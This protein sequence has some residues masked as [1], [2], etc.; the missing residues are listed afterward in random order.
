MPGFVFFRRKTIYPAA[1]T[2]PGAAIPES[3]RSINI[4]P[5]TII[6]MK[7][8]I[9]VVF[10]A[11]VC[12]LAAAQPK[13]VEKAISVIVEQNARAF[14]G[15]LASDA[16]QGRAAGSAS[17]LAAAEYLASYLMYLGIEPLFGD[18]YLQPFDAYNKDLQ[19]RTR[20]SVEPDSVAKYM[21]E[22]HHVLHMRNVAGIIR[23]ER[24]DEFVVV[25]AHFDHMGSDGNLVGD[26][27]YNGADDNASG[28][29]AVMQIARAFAE[30]SGHRPLRSIIFAFW[31]GEE[32]GLLGS[33]YFTLGC[34]F[35]SG[36]KAYINFDMI[37]R[38][39]GGESGDV[40]FFY[41]EAKGI[42]EEWTRRDIDEFGIKLSPAY[43]AWERPV[44]GSDNS[45]FARH[46]IPVMW[47]HTG[48]HPDYHKP[49]DHAEKINYEKL[50]V[51]TRSAFLNAWRLANEDNF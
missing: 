34:G 38:G 51:I 50:T 1:K 10:A 43:N 32:L 31:D 21:A 3:V 41:T 24:E 4:N 26:Q 37:G 16:L 33:R 27:I 25:G 6:Y 42:F 13:P 28:V 45:S 36:I 47:Y 44:G 46:D 30:S 9:L 48:P 29:S 15:F 8:I 39:D 40:I 23:G 12:V 19:T 22:A 17:G 20:Y 18:S 2:C 11:S 49:S 14:V 35:L 5:N 7:K